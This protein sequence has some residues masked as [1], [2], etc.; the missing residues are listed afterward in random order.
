MRLAL[1]LIPLGILLL[2]IGLGYWLE[3]VA[4]R[5]TRPLETAVPFTNKAAG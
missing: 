3:A 1:A 2:A 5:Q 4:A